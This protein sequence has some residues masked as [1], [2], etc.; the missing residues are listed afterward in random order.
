MGFLKQPNLQA[1]IFNLQTIFGKYLRNY[2]KIIRHL[3][4]WRTSYHTSARQ[5][6]HRSSLPFDAMQQNREKQL[7][8]VR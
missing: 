4:I 7:L 2:C 6:M 8:K 5:V 1:K 3:L